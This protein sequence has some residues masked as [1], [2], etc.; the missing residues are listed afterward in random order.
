MEERSIKPLIV[1][2]KRHSLEDGPGI[3]SVVFFK[4]CPM[5]CVFCHNSE[6]QEPEAEIVFSS[7]DCTRCGRCKGVCPSGAID[8]LEYPG[9]IKRDKCTRCGTC[10]AACLGKGLSLIGKHYETDELAEL[11][12]RDI[13]FYRHSGGGVTLSGGE[14]TMYPDYVEALLKQLKANNIHVVL[15]TA[16][17]F[18][19]EVFRKKILPYT[20][21]IYYDI[22]LADSEAHLRYT[23]KSN[24]LILENLRRLVSEDVRLHPRIPL[25]PGITTGK[26]NLSDIVDLLCSAGADDVTLLPYNPMG[27]EMAVKVGRS[28]PSLPEVFMKEEEERAAY[29]A[30]SEMIAKKRTKPLRKVMHR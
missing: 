24:R 23:G 6:T 25:I 2:V 11:L 1:D 9:R 19:F 8:D 12:L 28:V 10:T 30:L 15:E 27:M 16:G 4:G 5:R 7:S 17:F 13:T 21:F 20:D 18:D 14:C 29:S 22:K 26:D 3:R